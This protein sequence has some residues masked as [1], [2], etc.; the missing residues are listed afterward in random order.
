MSQA[1]SQACIHPCCL[2]ASQSTASP[3][4]VPCFLFTQVRFFPLSCSALPLLLTAHHQ[5]QTQVTLQLALFDDV[6]SSDSME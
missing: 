2:P 4:F 3:N 1:G 5:V 6:S